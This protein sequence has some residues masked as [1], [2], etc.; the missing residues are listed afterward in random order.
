MPEAIRSTGHTE[1]G[2]PAAPPRAPGKMFTGR[3]GCRVKQRRLRNGGRQE[4]AYGTSG[5]ALSA[6]RHRVH[7]NYSARSGVARNGPDMEVLTMTRILVLLD[8]SPLAAEAL[9]MARL[10]ARAL[11]A[12]VVLLSVYPL[13]RAVTELGGINPYPGRTTSLAHVD[14]YLRQVAESPTFEDLN[15]DHEVRMGPV[16][17][18]ILEAVNV[19]NVDVVV[20]TTHGAGTA[21][22]RPRGRIATE[23]VR[24]LPVPVLIAPPGKSIDR[25]A[26]ILVP[27]DGS[28]EADRALPFARRLSAGTGATLHL[29]IVCDAEPAFARTAQDAKEVSDSLA[30]AAGSHLHQVALS[31]E[32]TAVVNGHAVDGIVEYAQDHACDLIVMATHGRQGRL[33]MDLG[34]VSEG[35]L[36]SVDRPVLLIPARPRLSPSDLVSG[37]N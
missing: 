9:P 2:K 13:D 11:E 4:L 37:A 19:R 15:V 10:V 24:T 16:T 23:L 31:D 22:H 14:A 28:A 33:L 27:L 7:R 25:A 17:E 35:V 21:T 29:L 32:E 30:Y 36:S 5:L 6:V 1:W 20:M 3:R 34:S 8:G 18:Q 26:R 12:E